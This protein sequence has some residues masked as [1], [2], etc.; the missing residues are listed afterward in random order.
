MLYAHLKKLRRKEETTNIKKLSI[1][2]N[3]LIK[4]INNKSLDDSLSS[5]LLHQQLKLVFNNEA[6]FSSKVLLKGAADWGMTLY[7]CLPDQENIPSNI[8]YKAMAVEMQLN[9][10]CSFWLLTP[11]FDGKQRN[12]ELQTLLFVY[13]GADLFLFVGKW[14]HELS[15]WRRLIQFPFRNFESQ[16]LFIISIASILALI[17]PRTLLT[18]NPSKFWYD[19]IRVA[20]FFWLVILITAVMVYYIVGFRKG[21][22]STLSSKMVF[23]ARNASGSLKETI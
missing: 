20:Y 18:D 19:G 23:R 9:S 10:D 16:A 12:K 7:Q 22:N 2:I 1:E 14:G 17:T 11:N 5:I 21:L 8:Y 13:L 3:D 6:L 15:Q 4:G